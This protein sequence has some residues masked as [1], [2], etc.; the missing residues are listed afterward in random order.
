[1]KYYFRQKN[2]GTCEQTKHNIFKEKTPVQ[3]PEMFATYHL[4]QENPK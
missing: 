3:N 1:M 2:T 4:E